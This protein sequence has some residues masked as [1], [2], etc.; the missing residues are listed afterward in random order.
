MS[1]YIGTQPVPQ[2]TQTR[3]AFTATNNQT[4]FPTSG[5]TPEFLD[6]F[7]NGVKL[8][9]SDYT[10]TNGSDVV[11]AAGAT[12]G[13]ILEVVSYGTFEVLNPTF[14]GN[15]TFTGNASFG[16]N[17]KAIFGDGSDLEIYHDGTHS[18]VDDSSGT[19]RLILKTDYLEVQNAAGNEAILGGI[20]D[21]AVSLFYNGNTK[22]ATT[23]TGID[24]TGITTT[25]GLT[26]DSTVTVRGGNK[27]ILNRADNATRG[28]I[29]YVAGTGFV[30]NDLNGDGLSYN[31]NSTNKLRID[32][33][34]NV[35]I[36]TSNPASWAKLDILGSGGSQTGATQALQVKAPSATAGEGVGIRLNAA[37]GSHE[38]VGIIGMVNNA[39]GNAG[40]M[41]F[42]TYDGGATI[43]ER[44]RIDNSGNLLVGTTSTSLATTSSET[45][46]MITDGSFQAAANNPVAQ[47]NRIT[48][49]GSI[50]NFRKNGTTVGSIQARSSFTTLQIGSTGTGITGTS[51]HKILPSV[52]NARSDNTNDLGDSSYRWKDAYL[53]GGLYLGGVGSANKLEDYEEGTFTPFIRIN[54]GV[55]GITVSHASGAYVKV[56]SAVHIILRWRLSSK[57]SNVGNVRLDGL[58]FT[59]GDRIGTTGLEGGATIG[60]LS[61]MAGTWTNVVAY[62]SENETEIGF[63]IRTGTTGDYTAMT[64]SNIGNLFDGRIACTYFVD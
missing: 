56:G 5:Y 57:G 45:G 6:V 52:N 27:L 28:E 51:S 15:V 46:A 30:L 42:H 16:D 33:S 3:D 35:G 29:N 31:V 7:L 18:Y 2:A 26:S 59:V 32:A 61:G 4:S 39:S 49:D 54:N 63:S 44:M 10:A 23:S 62:P 36:G 8:A 24:V 14:D 48:S 11:L 21:G 12:T 43:P 19:G 53:A 58:P 34:G 37:S 1:G 60:F 55:E 38:A 40:S 13:D 22:L 9:A 20:Q 64:N 17:D 41:T 47:F 25:D 50:V